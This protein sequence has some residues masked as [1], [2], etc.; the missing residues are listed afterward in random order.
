[1]DHIKHTIRVDDINNLDKPA[2]GCLTQN[3]PF[4]FAALLRIRGICG[5]DNP[6]GLERRHTMRCGML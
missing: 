6:F 4:P 1:M 5:P 3:K 2:T